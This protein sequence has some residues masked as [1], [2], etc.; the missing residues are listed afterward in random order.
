[1]DSEDYA[2]ELRKLGGEC[3]ESPGNWAVGDG[4]DLNTVYICVYIHTIRIEDIFKNETGGGWRAQ[5]VE[6]AGVTRLWDSSIRKA[7]EVL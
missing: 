3:G 5:G 7:W 1:M 4:Y 6:T 2:H